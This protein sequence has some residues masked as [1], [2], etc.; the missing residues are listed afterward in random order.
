MNVEKEPNSTR[1]D[2]Q[3]MFHLSQTILSNDIH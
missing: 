2:V 1:N 3:H